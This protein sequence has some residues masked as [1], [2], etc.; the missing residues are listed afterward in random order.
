MA[1]SKLDRAARVPTA[2][3][4][5][6]CRVV[7]GNAAA[8]ERL[9]GVLRSLVLLMP[10]KL[11]I[12]SEAAAQTGAHTRPPRAQRASSGLCPR[13]LYAG[14]NLISLYNRLLILRAR[15]PSVALLDEIP[16]RAVGAL[17]WA[18]AVEHVA[19]VSEL[20]C[21]KRFGERG[22]M[23]AICAVE[24]VRS[25]LQLKLLYESSGRTIVLHHLSQVLP[26]HAGISE[27]PPC[28]LSQA[29][30][31]PLSL[32]ETRWWQRAARGRAVPLN[33]L[34]AEVLYALRPVI[35]LGVMLKCGTK[36]W[37]TWV[38][39]LA[40]EVLSRALHGDS[41]R[42]TPLERSEL[43]R[44]TMLWSLYVLRSPFYEAATGNRVALRLAELMERTP[45]LGALFGVIARFI[46]LYRKH[47]FNL[48]LL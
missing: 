23:A 44:R 25:A 40:V 34:A 20:V 10:A 47:H 41:A 38:A 37:K 42:M 21:K 46:A 9:E 7:E 16:P 33:R 26:H 24:L 30:T 14:V 4:S 8:V 39:G 29:V 35:T 32:P 3:A 1:M 2:L 27:E 17:T 36:S 12:K 48:S 19:L 18:A 45:V 28:S 15:A 5:A 31:G 22:R 6:Y 43:R 13:S 11:G